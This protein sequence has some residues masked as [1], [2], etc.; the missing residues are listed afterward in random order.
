MHSDV[1]DDAASV[2]SRGS[3]RPSAAPKLRPAGPPPKR[4]RATPSSSFRDHAPADDEEEAGGEDAEP[5]YEVVH[6][7]MRLLYAHMLVKRMC[8]G[9]NNC[10]VW[11]AFAFQN[12][13]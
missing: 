4:A 5:A 2:S 6:I 10:V 12:Q 3:H 8:Y 11:F 7:Y 13:T 1:V 9:C